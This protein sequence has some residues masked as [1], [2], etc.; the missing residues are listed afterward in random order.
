MTAYFNPNFAH[1]DL[2]LEDMEEEGQEKKKKRNRKQ[3]PIL[4]GGFDRVGVPDRVGA[5]LANC[6]AIKHTVQEHRFRGG[7][8]Y[9]QDMFLDI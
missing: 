5:F 6:I 1:L 2:T 3:L 9:L 8:A 7:G 4:A